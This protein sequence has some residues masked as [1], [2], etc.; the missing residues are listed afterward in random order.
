M[1]IF[2]DY[3]VGAGFMRFQ[4]DIEDDREEPSCYVD[5][6]D[7]E[8]EVEV[9]VEVEEKLPIKWWAKEKKED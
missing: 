5:D 4:N 9:E 6:D 1:G 3:G 7:D 8:I 2:D